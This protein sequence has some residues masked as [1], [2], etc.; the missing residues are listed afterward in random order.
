MRSNK[1]LVNEL[2]TAPGFWMDAAIVV[3]FENQFKFVAEDHPD[4][5]TRLNSLQELGGLAIG[6][7]GVRPTGYTDRAFVAQVFQEYEG[8]GW[9]HQYMDTLGRIVRGANSKLADISYLR[10]Q[11]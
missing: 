1:E 10:V 2:R 5:I 3:V 6:L 8:Q 7:A 9:A 11:L 4:P